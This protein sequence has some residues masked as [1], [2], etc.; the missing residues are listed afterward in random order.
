MNSEFF[1]EL[2]YGFISKNLLFEKVELKNYLNGSEIDDSLTTTKEVEE[3]VFILPIRLSDK[4]YILVEDFP[5]NFILSYGILIGE[6]VKLVEYE[7]LEKKYISTLQILEKMK[8]KF[9]ISDYKDIEVSGITDLDYFCNFSKPKIISEI[10]NKLLKNRKIDLF[11]TKL[12]SSNQISN[13]VPNND[14]THL[15]LAKE[16]NMDLK[17]LIIKNKIIEKNIHFNDFI[18][19]RKHLN[20]MYEEEIIFTSIFDL[21]FNKLYRDISCNYYLKIDSEKI[22]NQINNLDNFNFSKMNMIKGILKINSIKISSK[23][24][25]E[26]IP[27]WKTQEGFIKIKDK[28]DFKSFSGI[29]YEV[30]F[31]HLEKVQVMN[32]TGEICHFEGIFFDEK[33]LEIISS[34]M[35]DTTEFNSIE[36]LILKLTFFPN[37]KNVYFREEEIK[38]PPPKST[39]SFS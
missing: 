15:K 35:S 21:D 16:F 29:E 11:K 27:V 36:E 20:P 18:A 31:D 32:E 8:S 17:S 12:I 28:K 10:Q 37:I 7:I 5:I 24:G 13:F 9:E 34:K 4:R 38:N 23:E 14:L 3:K 33:F 2:M 22:S 26:L 1:L 19:M 30:V 6:R 25:N 39:S